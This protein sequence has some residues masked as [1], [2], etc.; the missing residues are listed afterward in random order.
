VT[1]ATV[2][3]FGSSASI[4]K[5]KGERKGERKNK[6]AAPL[7]DA[8]FELSRTISGTLAVE[9]KGEVGGKKKRPSPSL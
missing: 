2:K 8:A 3:R 5:K 1:V 4:L 7:H 6:A 9:E